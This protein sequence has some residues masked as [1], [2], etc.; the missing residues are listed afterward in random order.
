MLGLETEAGAVRVYPP[1]LPRDR[2][3]EEVARV[4]LHPRLSRADIQRAPAARFYQPAGVRETR[5]L[6]V[7]H[8]V[9]IVATSIPQLRVVLR[10]A[11][12][13][14][15]WRAE[16]ERRAGDCCDRAGRNERRVDGRECRRVE[17]QYVVEDVAI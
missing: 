4:E 10:D 15:R 13:D 6:P 17:R 16:I 11:R 3:V 14:R 9:V 12:A 1:A 7:E 5:C 2:A 8:P